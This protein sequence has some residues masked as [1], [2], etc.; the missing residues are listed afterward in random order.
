MRVVGG[1]PNKHANPSYKATKHIL[2]VFNTTYPQI[3]SK[4]EDLTLLH[5]P[6][7][8]MVIGWSN[9][10]GIGFSTHLKTALRTCYCFYSM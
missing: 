6:V 3:K 2:L 4:L 8:S 10:F 9:Y 5:R 7:C 1:Q